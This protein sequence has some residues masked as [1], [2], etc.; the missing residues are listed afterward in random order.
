MKLACGDTINPIELT[1]RGVFSPHGTA[2]AMV[3]KVNRG[4]QTFMEL[5]AELEELL[6]DCDLSHTALTVSL[7][8]DKDAMTLAHQWGL[9]APKLDDLI[10]ELKAA[11]ASPGIIPTQ[12][13]I[14]RASVIYDMLVTRSMT[15]VL[16]SP[17]AL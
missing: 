7:P 4:Q 5:V 1:F 17:L 3:L 11:V 6:E 13:S 9:I 14:V 10:Q 2:E 15:F 16:N 8:N 12:E